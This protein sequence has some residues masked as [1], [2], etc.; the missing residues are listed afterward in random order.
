MLKI[1]SY[2]KFYNGKKLR[3]VNKRYKKEINIFQKYLQKNKYYINIP[4]ITIIYDFNN[5]FL[6]NIKSNIVQF[7]DKLNYKYL[8][9][10]EIIILISKN[11][12]IIDN[13]AFKNYNLNKIRKIKIINIEKKEVSNYIIKLIQNINGKFVTILENFIILENDIIDKLYK[14]TIGKIDNIYEYKIKGNKNSFYL[15]NSRIFREIADK[16]IHFKIFHELISYILLLPKKYL[17]YISIAFC[18]DNNYIVNTYVSI[19]SILENKNYNTFVCFY[20]LIPNNFK[21]QNK[22]IIISLYDQ[23]DLFNITFI[24][25]DDRFNNVK[26]FRYISKA[27]YFKLTLSEYLPKLNKIL[28]LDSDIIVYKDLINLFNKNFNGFL[29]L[30][31]PI[32]NIFKFRN[33]SISYI[34]GVLLL[35]LQKMREIKFHEKVKNI[36]NSGFQDTKYHLHDQA[37]INNFF[38]EYIGELEPEYNY[39]AYLLNINKIYYLHKKD[40]FNYMNL[41]YSNKYPT[42]YHFTGKYKPN[43]IKREIV[44]T[45]GIM[46]IKG[47]PFISY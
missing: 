35:N 28:Y 14:K 46:Q 45:G 11:L 34:T 13:K 16:N 44:K 33:K 21:K 47:K 37:I 8:D 30:A 19:I 17:Y 29:I 20:I 31:T 27:A 22:Q 26:V 3:K 4:Y 10:I 24:K 5:I 25:T 12:S 2:I 32:Y 7:L 1:F 39:R 23:Y 38:Y 15:I 6:H 9:N 40:Y 36:V 18:L 41:I 42:I 43:K